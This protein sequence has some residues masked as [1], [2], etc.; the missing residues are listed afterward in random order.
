SGIRNEASKTRIFTLPKVGDYVVHEIH[1]IGRCIR[2]ERIKY[3][4]VERDYVVIEYAEGG[5]LQVP[6]DQMDR[7]SRYSG[8]DRVPKLSKLGGKDFEKT[9][10]QVEKSIK[11]MAINLV[12]L[13]AA[14]HKAKGHV[15]PPD[16][17][18]QKRFEDAFPYEET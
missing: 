9:K 4:D 3:R 1:G 11:K 16:T 18:E 17:P 8:S 7:L 13:Y 6:I 15:Y 14:R 12:Q 10:K 5:L 2:T